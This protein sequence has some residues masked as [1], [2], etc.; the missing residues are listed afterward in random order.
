MALQCA[1]CGRAQEGWTPLHRAVEYNQLECARMLLDR[2]ADANAKNNVR[3][4][5]RRL[6]STGAALRRR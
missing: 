4:H 1:L 3:A 5:V 6:A 2:G